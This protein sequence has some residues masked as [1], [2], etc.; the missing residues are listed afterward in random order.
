M[1]SAGNTYQVMILI[2]LIS[3]ILDRASHN[4]NPI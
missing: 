1:D 3:M 2:A 4:L